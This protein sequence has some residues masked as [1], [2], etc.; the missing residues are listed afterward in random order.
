MYLLEG[1]KLTQMC[2]LKYKS[3]QMYVKN[4]FSIYTVSEGWH[5]ACSTSPLLTKLVREQLT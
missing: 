1:L 2:Y 5:V 3:R 4:Y